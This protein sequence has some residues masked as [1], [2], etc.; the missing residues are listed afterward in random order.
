MY[1]CSSGLSSADSNIEL[2]EQ[3]RGGTFPKSRQSGINV[4]DLHG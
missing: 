3:F 4:P 2:K 1:V